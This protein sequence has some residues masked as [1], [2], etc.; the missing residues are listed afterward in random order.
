[1]FNAY[2][3]DTVTLIRKVGNVTW[4]EKTTARTDVKARVEGSTKMLRNAAGEMIVASY[5]VLINYTTLTVA[6]RIE[7]QGVSHPILSITVLRAFSKIDGLEVYL[8]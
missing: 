7:Y 1:M 8:G 2:M 3:T 4:S 6:D 5:K